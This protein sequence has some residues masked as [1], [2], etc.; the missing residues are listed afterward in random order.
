MRA[1][2]RSRTLPL[3]DP[4]RDCS[5]GGDNSGSDCSSTEPPEPFCRRAEQGH[6]SPHPGLTGPSIDRFLKCGGS[7]NVLFYPCKMPGLS[8]LHPSEHLFNTR[9][10]FFGSHLAPLCSVGD[11]VGLSGPRLHHV[12]L[13]KGTYVEGLMAQSDRVADYQARDIPNH[14][15]RQY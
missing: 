5:G 9:Q 15:S 7:G 2:Y 10:S 4:C 3:L 1:P 12:N 14:G 6:L 11:P 8:F 13:F